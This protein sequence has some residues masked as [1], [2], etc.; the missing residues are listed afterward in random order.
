MKF[1]VKTSLISF[2]LIFFAKQVSSQ[3]NAGIGLDYGSEVEEAGLDVRLGYKLDNQWNLVGD[4]SLFFLDND[5][6]FVECRYW[7]EINVNAHYYFLTEEQVI[8]PYGLAGLGFTFVGTEY[9]DHP[10]FG[11]SEFDDSELG[12]NLGGGIDFNVNERLKPF[13]EVKYL[14]SD[15]LDQ[16]EISVGVKYFLP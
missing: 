6:R 8:S 1:L 11:D 3:I 5:Q 14:L 13:A 7:N 9:D 15:D 10:A 4:A 12:L 16:G 2:I